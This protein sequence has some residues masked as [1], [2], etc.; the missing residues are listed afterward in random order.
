MRRSGMFLGWTPVSLKTLEFHL[1]QAEMT[2]HAKYQV[3][4]GNQSGVIKQSADQ[5]N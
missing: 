4:H 3:E 1:T 2:S 5:K